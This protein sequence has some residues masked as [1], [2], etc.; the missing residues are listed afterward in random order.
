MKGTATA[1]GAG[2][3]GQLTS[4]SQKQ[5]N[6]KDKDKI[7]LFPRADGAG[8]MLQGSVLKPPCRSGAGP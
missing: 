7:K 2:E 5:K 3:K 6:E 4:A 8:T 1:Q